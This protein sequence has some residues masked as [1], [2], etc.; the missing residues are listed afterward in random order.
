M[1][2]VICC[3]ICFYFHAL[4]VSTI[5]CRHVRYAAGE[6]T[7]YHCLA[8]RK[9]KWRGMGNSDK[10][11]QNNY[12]Y[13]I[14]LSL[15][16]RSSSQQMKVFCVNIAVFQHPF[17]ISCCSGVCCDLYVA[18]VLCHSLCYS[19]HSICFVRRGKNPMNYYRYSAHFVHFSLIQ[20]RMRF[21]LSYSLG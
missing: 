14:L 9:K 18:S 8:V 15:A 2:G 5:L 12:I 7:I 13:L 4:E 17:N 6:H 1:A 20:S 21:F 3:H 19:V 10:G 11:A 16:A